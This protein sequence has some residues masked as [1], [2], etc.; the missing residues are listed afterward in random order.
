MKRKSENVQGIAPNI[1]MKL[2]RICRVCSHCA[3]KAVLFGNKLCVQIFYFDMRSV[4]QSKMTHTCRKLELIQTFYLV[5]NSE[6][7]DIISVFY[8]HNVVK[9]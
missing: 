8:F 4:V 3:I 5:L 2:C 7:R 6:V 9:N 1:T